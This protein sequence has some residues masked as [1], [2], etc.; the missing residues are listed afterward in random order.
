MLNKIIWKTQYKL[1]QFKKKFVYYNLGIYILYITYIYTILCIYI[2]Y[3]MSI[4]MLRLRYHII[5]ITSTCN[6]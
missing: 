3:L 6:V 1:N 2:G 4:P 5:I